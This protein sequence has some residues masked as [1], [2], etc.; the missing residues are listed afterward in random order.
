[1]H[2]RR[3]AEGGFAIWIIPT[4]I[5]KYVMAM[6]FAYAGGQ[7]QPGNFSI[8]RQSIIGLV[9]ACLW[10]TVSYTIA[11][12]VLYGSLEAGLASTPGLAMEGVMNAVVFLI[13]AKPL[14]KIKLLK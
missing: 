1:M 5:I 2:T 9:L 10:M 7:A 3:C 4:L 13:L 8:N 6:I 14:Q 12:A 11:G